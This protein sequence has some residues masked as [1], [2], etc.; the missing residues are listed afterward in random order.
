MGVLNDGLELL[1]VMRK[2]LSAAQDK[3]IGD[4]ITE[5]R[6][7][8][9]ERDS[10]AVRVLDLSE[11]LRFKG[12][13]EYIAGATFVEGFDQEICPRCA[14]VEHKP[15]RLQ[16]MTVDGRGMKATCPQCKTAIGNRSPI[17]R[18]Q[19]EKSAAKRLA[20]G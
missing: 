4:L 16:D 1:E 6:H 7:V 13:V 5:I 2:G 18:Q 14:D 20:A 12:R 11:Q 17:T 9:T 15:V 3:E 19:A 10:L 8:Q